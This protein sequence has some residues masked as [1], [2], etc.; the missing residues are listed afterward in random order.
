MIFLQRF[1]QTLGDFSL[2][3]VLQMILN[4]CFFSKAVFR[5]WLGSSPWF[6]VVLGDVVW[7][8]GDLTHLA[9][10]CSIS[11]QPSKEITKPCRSLV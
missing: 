9:S 8:I 1:L 5:L 7:A 3:V 4:I 6:Y 10:A 11:K 2:G